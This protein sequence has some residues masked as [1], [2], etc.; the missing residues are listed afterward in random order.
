VTTALLARARRASGSRV[1]SFEFQPPPPALPARARVAAV[2]CES[3]NLYRPGCAWT[4][5]PVSTVMFQLLHAQALALLIYV[6]RVAGMRHEP[7]SRL[8]SETWLSADGKQW[9]STVEW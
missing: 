8:H 5:S 9:A 7:A 1:R 3:S 2:T 6:L 4:F